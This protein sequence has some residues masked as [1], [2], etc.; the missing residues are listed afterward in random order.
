MPRNDTPI[1]RALSFEHC[2]QRFPYISYP[3]GGDWSQVES[4][5][6]SASNSMKRL[7]RH[8]P[9][10]PASDR[11]HEQSLKLCDRA[12]VLIKRN[13]RGCPRLQRCGEMEGVES[14]NGHWKRQQQLLGAAM[15]GRRELDV[16][17]GRR[18]LQRLTMEVAGLSAREN[19]FSRAPSERRSHFGQR[20]IREDHSACTEERLIQRI[21]FRL[22]DE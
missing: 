1:R 14:A 12:Q 9:R 22:L 20:Q 4:A 8:D 13:H 6:R 16:T 7:R 11:R 19:A 5:E 3:A 2:C 10:S 15:N 18:Q 21:A 17:A